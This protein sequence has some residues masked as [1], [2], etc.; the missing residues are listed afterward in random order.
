MNGLINLSQA[1]RELAKANDI[2]E[3]RDMADKAAAVQQYARRA[4]LGHDVENDA[5]E[6]KL[7]AERRAGELLLEAGFGQHGGDRKS[8]NGLL[9]EDMGV[10]KMQ[11]SRWQQVANVPSETFEQY[12]AKTRDSGKLITTAG[13]VKLAARQPRQV[14]PQQLGAAAECYDSLRE[15]MGRKFG[16]IYADPPWAYSNQSTRAATDNHY[17]TLT[18]DELINWPIE[19]LAADDAH[20][21]LWTTNAFLPESF[22]IIEAWGF[23][24]KSCFVWVKPQM[25]IGNY[26]RVSHEFLL[27][28]VRGDAKRFNDRALRSWLEAKRGKHSAKPGEVREMIERAS[29]GPYLEL[30]GRLA[31]GGWTVIGN[32]VE[33]MLFA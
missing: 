17:D 29:P 26:W 6:F 8:S 10:G 14:E 33:E 7:R 24:Y 32:Q 11:S 4:K 22:R 30:F 25:G 31:V 18:V 9:L 15:I 13:V 2:S 21:H 5:A 3:V 28:G 16:C 20:L 1:C 27:L 23:E 12:L 19:Q